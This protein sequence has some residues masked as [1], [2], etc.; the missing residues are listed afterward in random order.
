MKRKPIW[1]VVV[2]LFAFVFLSCGTNK[3]IT[4]NVE[5]AITQ[6]EIQ[7]SEIVSEL[8]EQARQSYVSALA[9]QE[10]NSVT[11]AINNYE[12]ALR[13][14]NNLSYY[15][16]IEENDAYTELSASIIDDYKSYID[17]LPEL[18]ENASFAA[19]EEW[20]GKSIP[21][22]ALASNKKVSEPRARIVIDS[23]IPLVINDEVQQWIDYFQGR[24]KKH[25]SLWLSRSG[26]YFPAMKEIFTNE[27]TPQQLL[28]LSMIESGVN[29]TARSW[30]GAVGM[31]QFMRAT[32]R[33][34]GLTSD[35][36]FDERRDVFKSSKAAARHLKDL[37][38]SLGDWYLAL[39]SYNA[40]EGRIQRA[41]RRSGS[42]D[43]WEIQKYLPKET[44]SYVPQYIAAT[45]IAMDPEKYGF[46]DFELQ[47]KLEFETIKVSEAIDLDYFASTCK[48]SVEDL[49][50]LNPELT[51]NSTPSNYW[52]G[53]ELKIPIGSSTLFAAALENVPQ[54]AKRQYA[55]HTV[56]RGETL[57]KVASL[58]GI[59]KNDLADANNI[60]VKTRL[61]RGVKLK[62]PYKS[63]FTSTDFAYNSN[64]A[65]AVEPSSETNSDDE[66]VS[67]YK[68]INNEK[69]AQLPS[70]MNDTH[71]A[72]SEDSGSE[73]NDTAV[74]QEQPIQLKPAGK[75]A[76]AYKVKQNE[77]LL[78]IADLFNVRVTDLR[79]WNNIPYTESIK[80]SQDLKIFVPE[81]KAD[82]YASLDNQTTQE[83]TTRSSVSVNK[84]AW[85]YY[86]V[87]RGDNLSAIAAKYKVSLAVLKDWNN[88]TSNRVNA[89]Q[90]LKISTETNNSN[91][92]SVVEK[93]EKISSSQRTFRYKVHRG[94]SL[95]KIA[96]KFGVRIN[97]IRKWNHLPSNDIAAGKILKI[98]DAGSSTASMGDAISKT[99]GILTNYTVK[100]GETIGE[101]AEQFH[102][103]TSE[104]KKW[105]AIKRNNIL[106]GQKLKI[107]SDSEPVSKTSRRSQDSVTKKSS[108]STSY[109]VRK[110]DSLDSIAKRFNLEITEI[111][112]LNRLNSNKIIVGQKLVLN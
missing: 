103:S 104:I 94:E 61:K 4:K 62:I 82:Y 48:I 16:G 65:S 45:L 47:K 54:S 27:G 108:K 89:G 18:P 78:G 2:S 99:P 31:W 21:E 24:G 63:T 100:K 13:I 37:Y 83:K 11:E 112:Q 40:G 107:Y 85:T 34:Y 79:N 12:N 69:L 110:G 60:S 109:K 14:T 46:T 67:P 23:E 70:L 35:F 106:A 73:D 55:F 64:E 3:E 56:K 7:K 22:L 84:R 32:G 39:A 50:D 96:E 49:G 8:L 105:N 57:N 51:M 59:S 98:Y 80:V 111:K 43:F 28:F 19:L 90:K 74:E 97:Q 42:K 93:T 92:A 29:P 17:A 36:H 1:L 86:K 15:P 76:V 52:G 44:R 25:M 20:I 38:N 30:V 66:Y 81:D 77:S 41:I 71:D 88:L 26:K 9:K 87:R 91:F 72:A 33:I 95:G 5:A 102:V 10:I 6:P 75:V 53:Y 101:I 68:N 58:Y